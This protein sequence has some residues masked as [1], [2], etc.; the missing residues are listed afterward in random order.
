METSIKISR[1][2]FPD[3]SY[4]YTVEVVQADERLLEDFLKIAEFG[5]IHA[6]DIPDMRRSIMFLELKSENVV[7]KLA[8]SIGTAIVNA[9]GK[10]V[11][12]WW[13]WMTR[14]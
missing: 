6:S 1:E 3:K 7:S 14:R 5:Y 4:T 13:T 9:T 8:D 12:I 11:H 10:S 2:L